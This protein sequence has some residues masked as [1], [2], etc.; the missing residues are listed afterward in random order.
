LPV[1]GLDDVVAMA[2]RLGADTIAVTSASETADEYLRQL[3]WQLE[4]SGMELLVA[5]GL[6]EVAGPRLHIR[7]F[8]GLQLL[9]LEA[10]RF[11]GWS[12]LVKG[13][14]DRSVAALALVLLAPVL[15][16]IGLAVRMTSDG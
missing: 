7:P 13:G 2:R 11:E 6:I 1:G 4:G 16:G 5:P 3:S 8:E 14:V 12:R 10:P 9:T 15:L